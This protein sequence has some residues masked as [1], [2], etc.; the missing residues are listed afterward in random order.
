MKYVVNDFEFKH[1]SDIDCRIATLRAVLEVEGISLSVAEILIMARA[2]SFRFFDANA[3]IPK[4]FPA[5]SLLGAK[6][7]IIEEFSKYSGV[8]ISCH[9]GQ[10]SEE[11][12]EIIKAAITN[13]HCVIAKGDRHGMP[14]VLSP[15]LLNKTNVKTHMTQ[16]YFIIY[17]VDTR[18]KQYLICETASTLE[19]YYH[20]WV[21]IEKLA[22]I[23]QC[24][25]LDFDIDRDI[26]IIEDVKD[27]CGVDISRDFKAQVEGLEQDLQCSL[28]A[29]EDFLLQFGLDS[30]EI[31]RRYLT[32]L[33]RM[34]GL[35][36]GGFDM[37][38][39]FYRKYLDEMIRQT[40]TQAELLALS[41]AHAER[42]KDIVTK[43][44]NV[45]KYEQMYQLWQDVVALG[46]EELSLIHILMRLWR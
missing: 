4:K 3:K 32:A 34:L 18:K 17:G 33:T 45:D 31:Y 35:S 13:N 7:D 38:G 5:M 2:I 26:Y 21:D 37:S 29:L 24:Q 14:S 9:R 46:K 6:M 10:S 8:N 11:D 40:T 28:T 15:R 43:I 19:K 12:F 1:E 20:V 42:C 39:Y 25:W 22:Q 41:S 27:F 44:R 16:H 36:M 23:R 30:D